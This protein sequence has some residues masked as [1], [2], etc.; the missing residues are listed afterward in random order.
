MCLRL[1]PQDNSEVHFKVKMTTKFEKVRVRRA[2]DRD[3]VL[4]PSTPPVRARPPPNTSLTADLATRATF[5]PDLQR[6]LLA[7]A[8]QPDAVRFLFDGS[9]I[10]PNQTPKDVRFATRPVA[11]LPPRSRTRIRSRGVPRIWV[12]RS[13]SGEAKTLFR[14]PV[15]PIRVSRKSNLAPLSP[16]QL[17][18]EDGDSIDAMMEQVGGH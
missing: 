4:Y 3:R 13:D 14:R 9:R 8:L 1:D 11:S 15:R 7:Q 16:S 18:M 17:D 5:P 10:N 12:P 2:P 6:L